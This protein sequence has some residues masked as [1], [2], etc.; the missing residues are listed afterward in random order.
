MKK[1][2]KPSIRQKD[3]CDS[4]KNLNYREK[5]IK[6]SE[7]YDLNIYDVDKLLEEE[8]ELEQAD[9][10]FA[11]YMKN[12]Y[13]NRFT[14]SSNSYKDSYKIYKKLRTS[15]EIC[16]YCNYS[17]RTVKQLD[18]YLPKSIFPS[19]SITAN[20]LVPSC[21]D[22]NEDK[23][24]YYSTKKEGMLIHPYYDQVANDISKFL[25][26]EIIEDENIGFEFYIE[27]LHVWDKD[28][29]KRVELH[30]EKLNLN[31][32]YQGDFI[33]DFIGFIE[34]TKAIKDLLP[35][36]DKK[37]IKKMVERKLLSLENQNKK[38]WSCSGFRSILES[39][40]CINTYLP[41]KFDVID[42]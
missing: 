15:V 19:F 2:D 37:M 18:H 29:L 16:P 5:I 38:P 30:F 17:A 25:K 40:W 35:D 10:N 14:S 41:Q 34:D 42:I 13:S 26:C 28:V 4:F 27:E 22:C 21:R 23:G 9:N 31:K 3:I 20:N 32:L 1:I 7:E 6:R 8:K 11:Q 12:T 33:A 39:E 24:H 36:L